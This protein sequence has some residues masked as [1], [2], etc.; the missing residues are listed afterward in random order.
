MF[1]QFCWCK[2]I[3]NHLVPV[4][5]FH[6]DILPFYSHSP[7]MYPFYPIFG[8]W[9]PCVFRSASTHGQTAGSRHTQIVVS[10]LY[11]S[12]KHIKHHSRPFM[13]MFF[14][15]FQPHPTPNQLLKTPQISLFFFDWNSFKNPT[16]WAI[17]TLTYL[18]CELPTSYFLYP[19]S[20]YIYI[21]LY[22]PSYMGVSINGVGTQ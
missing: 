20:L 16:N 2:T 7:M 8:S 19:I 18:K 21:W 10:W 11:R 12:I 6:T 5:F 15:H 22:D 1:Y 9:P 14:V 4:G 17:P 3:H 13:S